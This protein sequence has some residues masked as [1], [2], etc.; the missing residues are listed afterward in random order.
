LFVSQVLYHWD[1]VNFAYALRELDVIQ[2]QPQPP[3][4]ILYVWLARLVDVFFGDAQ[5]VMV[6]ISVVA[7]AL[8]VAALFYLGRAMYERRTGLIAAAFLASSPLFWFYGEIAL[9][10]SLDMLLVIV[11]LWWLY[12]TMRGQT[13]YLYPAIVM[14]AVAGGVRQQTLIFMAPLIVFSLRRVGWRRFVA[15]GALGAV[16]CLAWFIP[17]AASSGGVGPYLD[18]VDSFSRQFDVHTSVLMGAGMSGVRYNLRKWVPYTLYGWSVA[19]LPFAAY[20]VAQLWRKERPREWEK[21]WFFAL[22]LLPTLLF[23]T[24]VHMGQQGLVF[25]FLPALLLWGA[26]GLA[27]LLQHRSPRALHVLV[28]V[29]VAFN[30]ALF[31]LGPEYPLGQDSPRLLTRSTLVNS[32]HYYGDRFDAIENNLSPSSTAIMAINWHHVEYYLPDYALLPVD[33]A[34][35]QTRNIGPTEEPVSIS[36]QDL[37]LAPGADDLVNVVLFD[38]LFAL[39]GDAPAW[40]QSSGLAH[41]GQIKV[42][43]LPLDYTLYRQEHV[44][45]VREP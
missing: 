25:V 18:K 42:L 36:L 45:D 24:F 10:H 15:A 31:C 19:F 28:A 29:I 16:L 32:D 43:T 17:L 39:T 30:V 41:G 8:A 44:V 12:E 33:I 35:Q 4:Y 26:R 7:S 22:W 11:S 1:S 9:P 37:G 5:A 3:G 13:R 27:C 6:C 14:L 23:Y 38:D 34:S 40:A 2:E 20:V 21:G